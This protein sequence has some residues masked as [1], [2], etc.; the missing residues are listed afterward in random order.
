VIE[1][2]KRFAETA[3]RLPTLFDLEERLLSLTAAFETPEAERTE[4]QSLQIADLDALLGRKVEGYCEVIRTFQ[5]LAD[6]RKADADRLLAKARSHAAV[7]ERLK[8]RLAEH[9]AHT[10]QDRIV[11]TRYTLDR[12]SYP[13][14]EVTDASAV[15]GDYQRTRVDISVDKAAILKA[16]RER[17][18]RV[19]GT[20]IVF[21]DGVVIS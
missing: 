6:S 8:A 13:H 21:E 19:E 18:E 17:K 5:T 11:T 12:R 3:E 15:P 2:S 16:Y 1:V 4:E 20:E 10:G 7:V 9:M 14:V